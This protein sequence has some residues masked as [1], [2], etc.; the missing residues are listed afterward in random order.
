VLTYTTGLFER[1]QEISRTGGWEYDVAADRHTWTDEVF[2]IFGR[3]PVAGPP[4]PSELLAYVHPDD[5]QAALAA[6]RGALGSDKRAEL[7]VRIRASDG[8][9]RTVHL[10][11]SRDPRRIRVVPRARP[12]M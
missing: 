2:R 4:S 7:D 11:V 6:Y 5:S 3:D 10:I 9:Q 1:T 12:R 8:T